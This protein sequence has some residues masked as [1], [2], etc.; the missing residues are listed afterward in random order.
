MKGV[1][2]RINCEKFQGLLSQTMYKTYHHV[3]LTN[4]E[5]SVCRDAPASSWVD[6]I[7]MQS[8][9]NNVQVQPTP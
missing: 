9:A 4:V 5:S 1:V 7:Q 6:T 3:Y 2:S 8:Y